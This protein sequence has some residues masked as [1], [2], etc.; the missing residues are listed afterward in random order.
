MSKQTNVLSLSL[1]WYFFVVVNTVFVV[2]VTGWAVGSALY[3]A[4]CA[5][6]PQRAGLAVVAV[7]C[8]GHTSAQRPSH[9]GRAPCQNC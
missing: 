1:V 8:K 2:F 3:P 7:A 5:Q 6:V 4:Q 9:R